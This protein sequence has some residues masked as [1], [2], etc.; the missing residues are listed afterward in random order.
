MENIQL[1]IAVMLDAVL[2]V[3]EI[4]S[5]NGEQKQIQSMTYGLLENYL[6]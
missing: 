5:R 3:H 1:Q 6:P 4:G 2:L